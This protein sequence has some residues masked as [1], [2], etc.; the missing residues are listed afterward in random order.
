VAK[1]QGMSLGLTL[2]REENSAALLGG[3]N[4]VIGCCGIDCWSSSSG[5][6][7]EGSLYKNQGL[8]MKGMATGLRSCEDIV[9]IIYQVF[10]DRNRSLFS[11]GLIDIFT[12]ESSINS[13]T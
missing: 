3:E 1:P 10:A 4:V 12:G 6:G 5:V 7:F 2:E 8:P 9:H 11:G 13:L